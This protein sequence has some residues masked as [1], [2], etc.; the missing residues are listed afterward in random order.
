MSQTSY[1]IE[2]NEAFAGM[3]VDSRFDTVESKLVEAPAGVGLAF[4]LGL[5]SGIEDAVNQVR[6]PAKV[7]SVLSADADLITSNSTVVTINGDALDAVVFDTDHDTT[8]A[9]IAAEIADH[10][11][12]YSATVTASRD[13]TIIGKDGIAISASAVT[14]GGA[15][16]AGWTQVQSDPGV[17]RGVLVH[18]H[19]EKALTTGIA[20]L[21]D[22]DAADVLR[23]GEIWLPYTD[24]PVV[25]AALYINL[26]TAN[27]EGYATDESSGNIAVPGG[28]IRE[29]NTSL[30]LLKAEINLP[31]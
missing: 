5:M 12:V 17:F 8:M 16:Q 14:T 30:S 13:I 19:V 25:D 21:V 11:D 27:Y 15:S 9:L 24:T 10:E 31:Q 4:G 7:K 28:K 29:V 22:Q 3:K 6:L 18:R 20:Q 1:N 23:K 2:H 26:A